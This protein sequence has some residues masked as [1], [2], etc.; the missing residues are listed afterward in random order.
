VRGAASLASEIAADSAAAIAKPGSGETFEALDAA[1]AVAK[2]AWIHA[3]AQQAEAGFEDPALGW[4]GVRAESASGRVHAEVV[5]GSADAAQALSGHMAGL[6]AYLAE[7]HA[8]VETLTLT[9][10]ENRWT[11]TA[12]DRNPGEAGTQQG[13]GQQPGQHTE[14]SAESGSQLA[15]MEGSAAGTLAASLSSDSGGISEPWSLGGVHI[16]VVA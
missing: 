15:P 8:Q 7:H 4:I 2:P 11:G 6:N 3:R 10:P 5:S 9:A 12:S 13:A 16:S 14:T 1:G